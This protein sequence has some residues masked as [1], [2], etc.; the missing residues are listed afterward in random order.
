M[1]PTR[2]GLPEA[3]VLPDGEELD[4]VEVSDDELPKLPGPLG[5]ELL[6]AVSSAVHADTATKMPRR[7]RLDFIIN[8]PL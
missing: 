1:K 8:T 2:I 7:P 6:H 4:A 5:L 3:A